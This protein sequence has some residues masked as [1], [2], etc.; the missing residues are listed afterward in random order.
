MHRRKIHVQ[1]GLSN[2]STLLVVLGIVAVVLI[3]IYAVVRWRGNLGQ[4]PFGRLTIEV[5]SSPEDSEI[6]IDGKSAGISKASRDLPAGKHELLVSRRGYRQ[7]QQTIVASGSLAIPVTLQPIPMDLRILPGQEKA[8]VWLDNQPL[9]GSLDESGAWTLTGVSQG[10]HSVR[11]KTPAGESTVSFDF[12]NGNPA[13]PILPE[14]NPIILFV[15]SADGNIRAE[16]NCTSELQLSDSSQPL[17]PGKAA[18]FMLMDGKYSAELKSLSDP[19]KA[20]GI[21]VNPTSETTMAVFWPAPAPVKDKKPV[22]NIQSL[23]SSA[24]DLMRD[25]K[26]DAA[27]ANVDQVL[28]KDAGSADALGISRRITRL[29]S[30]GGCR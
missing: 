15:S 3:S 9:A 16:C 21:N 4:I 27:Q 2:I 20:V 23:L 13:A 8:D 6:T 24:M 12:R 28:S 14:G 29:R 25:S 26:C 30:V 5:T 18:T 19:K 11:I 10:T 22:V 1:S 17:E 7:W